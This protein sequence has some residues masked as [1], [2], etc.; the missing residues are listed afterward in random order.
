MSVTRCSILT[1][2]LLISNLAGLAAAQ[3]TRPVAEEVTADATAKLAAVNP[4][5][6]RLSYVEG[7]VRVSPGRL[8]GHGGVAPWEQ[9][10]V[11]LPLET[12]FSVVTG[13]GRAEIEFEDASTMYLNSNTV[14]TFNDLTTRHGVPSTQM[15]LLTGT[16]TLHL[17]PTMAGEV[18]YLQTPSDSLHVP[19]GS[20]ADLRVDSYLDAMT[21]TPEKSASITLNG[22]PPAMTSVGT[23]FTYSHGAVVATTKPTPGAVSEWDQW[24]AN[25]VATRAAAMSA[26]M[27]DAG[28]ETPL[29]GLAD[30]SQKG[31][32]FTCEPYGTCWEPTNGWSGARGGQSTTTSGTQ[33]QNASGQ[34]QQASN[35]TQPDARTSG[36]ITIGSGAAPVAWDYDAFD[37][38]PCSPFGVQDLLDRDLGD[39][40]V[41]SL[42]GP[43]DFSGS[44]FNWAVCHAGSWIQRNGRY[45]WVVGTR[46][47]HHCPVHWVKAGGKLGYVPIHPRDVAG[48]EPLNLKHGVFE[49][50]GRKDGTVRLVAYE[51][52]K[53]VEML[54]RIP[55][56]YRA[57]SLPLTAAVK[58]PSVEAH[59]WTDTRPGAKVSITDRP[60][61]TIAFDKRAQSFTLVTRMTTGNRISTV[62]SPM[63][64]RVGTSQS[65]GPIF[66]GGYGGGSS[67]AGSHGSSSTGSSGG[68]FHGSSGASAGGSAPSGGGAGSSA[69]GGHK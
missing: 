44:P 13:K 36:P 69:G 68:S 63:G 6:V 27:R 61:S 67:N 62:S 59:A 31:H 15:A 49:P 64:A 10:K 12:G 4:Q 8:A 47:H 23:S 22:G 51:P 11:N 25:R 66:H 5:I 29:Q 17:V 53:P 43:F 30:L 57:P 60:V 37:D 34:P 54:T 20:R 42:Y 14:L 21:L 3:A 46:R 45:A 16:A 33:V 40:E 32:F 19:F 18:Y 65:G 26:V 55:K 28:L 2:S 48:K 9:A 41:S 1:L 56:Q 35:V 24:V 50:I 52:A 38:F 58:P 7:D 39:A